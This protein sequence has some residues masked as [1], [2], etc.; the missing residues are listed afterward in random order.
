[1]VWGWD[2]LQIFICGYPVFTASF[3]KKTVLSPLNSHDAFIKNLLI[4]YVRVYFWALYSIS[5]VYMCVFIPVPY[6][7]DYCSFVVSFEIR[8]WEFIQFRSF[9]W[10][11]QLSGVP[12]DSTWI[13]RWVFLFLQKSHWNF[14]RDC[15][16]SVDQFGGQLPF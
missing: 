11:F 14:D 7:F 9:S 4:I 8:K 16:E 13:L 15:I 1:M 6:C 12:S 2:P 5:L 3:V 10:L